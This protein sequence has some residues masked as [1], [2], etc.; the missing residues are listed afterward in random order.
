M[1]ASLDLKA[2]FSKLMMLTGAPLPRPLRSARAA[3][4]PG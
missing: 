4:S 3:P 1:L 2:E